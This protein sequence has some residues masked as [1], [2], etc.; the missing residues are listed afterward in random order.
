MNLPS[1]QIAVALNASV[2]E[3]DE[4][5]DEP[6]EL[7]RVE[8]ILASLFDE[9]DPVVAAAAVLSRITRSQAFTEGNKRTAT[10]LALW[11]LKENGI[12]ESGLIF[13]EDLV[14]AQL[15]LRAARGEKMD[16]EIL[17][18]LESRVKPFE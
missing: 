2:R 18:L 3:A 7:S 17:S 10:L 8:A 14:L 15:L 13:E 9:T 16:S 12:Q 5:F 11:I 4:W 1:L 6:D